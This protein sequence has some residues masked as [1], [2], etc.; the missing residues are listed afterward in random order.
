MSVQNLSSQAAIDK[1]KE[2]VDN[3]DI[4]L[5]C[6]AIDKGSLHAVPMSRQ[7]VD[8]QGNIWFIANADSDTCRNIN[9]DKKVSLHFSKVSD[10]EFLIVTGT[11]ELSRDQAR[12]DKYWN[13]FMEAWFE[14]GKED[15]NICLIKVTS[16]A[17]EYWETKDGK[18]L[19]MLKIA[20]SALT[21]K[22][23]D[24]GNEGTLNL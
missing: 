8:E 16:E 18:V 11:A 9:A 21:G 10:Y 13:S 22:S 4:C 2:L 19:T 23:F 14:Q 1:L 5:F 7:E 20:A 15:P 12:I 3:I 6:T 24:T 17:A